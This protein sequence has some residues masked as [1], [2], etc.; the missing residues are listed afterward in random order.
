MT[1]SRSL[2]QLYENSAITLQWRNL[3]ISVE[4]V[5]QNVLT[6]NNFTLKL[7]KVTISC[8]INNNGD[9]YISGFVQKKK[10]SFLFL[11]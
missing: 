7:L 1:L 3:F 6:K 8:M 11:I 5:I 9:I 10:F 4:T 2:K